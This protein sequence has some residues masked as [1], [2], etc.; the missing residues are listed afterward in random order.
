MTRSPTVMVTGASGFIGQALVKKLLQHGYIVH[1]LDKHPLRLPG[2]IDHQI[3]LSLFSFRTSHLAP[4]TYDVLYHLAWHGSPANPTSDEA[5]NSLNVEPSIRFI[6]QAVQAGVKH[7]VFISSA[8]SVYGETK[9][10][11]KETYKHNPQSAYGRGKYA[12]EEYLKQ[13]AS[14]TT[15]MTVFRTTNVIGKH[16]PFKNNQGIIPLL[17]HAAKSDQTLTLYGN[18]QKDYIA[19]EDV[20]TALLAASKQ[21]ASYR[22][23][24]LGSGQLIT[25]SDL[26]SLI[27]QT[28]QIK[29]H[30][31]KKKAS[32]FDPQHVMVDT[33]L[34]RRELGWS[35]K[36]DISQLLTLLI[37]HQL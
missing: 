9:Y 20:I 3:P 31:H 24:N 21:N 33:S 11:V 1:T 13:L 34:I 17:I 22:L 25:L 30:L 6:H 27:E 14:P 16:Q 36:T 5:V 35:P 15:K 19:I 12:V 4:R 23:Y 29:L 28:F 7:I 2:C 26:V 37:R 8:G 18:S 32:K 10:P